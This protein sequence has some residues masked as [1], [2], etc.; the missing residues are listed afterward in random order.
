M[1]DVVPIKSDMKQTVIDA[2]LR[3]APDS[4]I[5]GGIGQKK[6]E[7]MEQP[8]PNLI[9]CASVLDVF[10]LGVIL[11]V[12]PSLF[13]G[14]WYEHHSPRLGLFPVFIAVVFHG[15]SLR[16]LERCAWEDHFS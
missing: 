3:R 4:S 15:P 7:I 14:V 12:I 8:S 6:N 16:S 1:G 2:K 9:L 10:T 11:P 13:F 5:L